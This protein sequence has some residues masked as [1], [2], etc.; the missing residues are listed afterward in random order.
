M[1]AAR[2]W[3][4]ALVGGQIAGLGFYHGFWNMVLRVL[5]VL[6]M[7]A[8]TCDVVADMWKLSGIYPAQPTL[9]PVSRFDSTLS[10]VYLGGNTQQ[11][12][13]CLL[14]CAI[15]NFNL[16]VLT[17]FLLD[18]RPYIRLC[19]SASGGKILLQTEQQFPEKDSS[20]VKWWSA[21]RES[22]RLLVQSLAMSY[23]KNAILT[24]TLHWTFISKMKWQPSSKAQIFH[25][26]FLVPT[27]CTWW[28]CWLKE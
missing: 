22:R 25:I 21:W 18:S 15:A 10:N 12:F 4:V 19:S 3:R 13:V 27:N 23:H 16:W 5:H 14:P 6:A 28:T 2:G 7:G 1:A 8:G 24:L 17:S 9:A 20:V 11:C 26:W